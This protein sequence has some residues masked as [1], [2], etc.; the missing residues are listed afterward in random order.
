MQCGAIVH[1]LS[2]TK[3][4]L[5]LT[6]RVPLCYLGSRWLDPGQQHTLFNTII[7]SSTLSMLLLRWFALLKYFHCISEYE[8]MAFPVERP[9]STIYEIYF[10]FS[11]GETQVYFSSCDVQM[12]LAP[13]I[14]S[15]WWNARSLITFNQHKSGGHF[16]P[17]G[18]KSCFD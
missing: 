9:P 8:E 4:W 6:R 2:P 10:F 12:S 3:T 18:K 14:D 16:N 11:P 7:H 5:V 15:W 1:S 17:N 13:E